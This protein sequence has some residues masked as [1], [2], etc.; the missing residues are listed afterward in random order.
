[1]VAVHRL[2]AAAD[3]DAALIARI[4]AGDGVAIEPG[5]A[6]EVDARCAAARRVLADGQPVYGVTTGMGALSGIRLTRAQQLEHQRNLLLAR[7]T[8]GPPW[9]PAADVRALFAVR[10]ATFL[11][12]D[13]GVS[14]ALGQRLADFLAAGITPAVPQEAAGSAG[15]I[16]PLAHAF[17]PLVGIGHV[18]TSGDPAQPIRP[19][20]GA[21]GAAGARRAL[22]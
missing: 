20:A 8:G 7:A 13:A 22:P 18:L 4:A 19:A 1:V 17:G 21:I 14:A 10:L 15:E 12:P 5:L 16:V 11:T 3:L 6:R 9:L 2:A